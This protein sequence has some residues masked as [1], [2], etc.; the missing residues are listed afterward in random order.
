MSDEYGPRVK[1][2]G[3]WQNTTKNGVSFL[4]GDIGNYAQIQIWPNKKRDG[5]KD[6]DYTLYFCEKKRRDGTA[7]GNNGDSARSQFPSSGSH[8]ADPS[9]EEIPF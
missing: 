9:I 7:N 6:P 1:I 3:L 5:K 4:S 2:G 8:N